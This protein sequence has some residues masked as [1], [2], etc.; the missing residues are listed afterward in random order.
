M[1]QSTEGYKGLRPPRGGKIALQVDGWGG[2]EL[3]AI[4]KRGVGNL[5]IL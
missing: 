5:I 4:F 3:Y 2:K 1:D